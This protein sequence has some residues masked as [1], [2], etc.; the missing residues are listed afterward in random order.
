MSTHVQVEPHD[1]THHGAHRAIARAV[2][3]GRTTWG[4]V[5]KSHPHVAPSATKAYEWMFGHMAVPNQRNRRGCQRYST[6][7]SHPVRMQWQAAKDMHH[8]MKLRNPKAWRL[9]GVEAATR[10]HYAEIP[11]HILQIVRNG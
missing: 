8:Q 3:R 6:V 2:K 7:S 9:H 4:A 5:A 1:Y 11:D 10:R